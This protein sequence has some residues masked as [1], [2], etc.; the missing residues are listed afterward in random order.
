ML[1]VAER[2]FAEQGL[3]AVSLR[4]VGQEAGQRNNSA[5]QYHFGSRQGLIEAII[6]T[7]SRPV[8]AR[9][10]ELAARASARPDP[11]VRE[12]VG[13]LVLPLVETL[14]SPSHYLRFLARVVEQEEPGVVP[15]S[16]SQRSLRYMHR[17]LR[18]RLPE[19]SAVTF[20]R[21]LR[22]ATAIGLRTLADLEREA[23]SGSAPD[24]RVVVADLLVMLEALML[25]PDP[26]PTSGPGQ[27]K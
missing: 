4:A 2:L 16:P 9:R 21:R 25:A 18:A 26:A 1:E 17:E 12:L 24:T 15:D 6:E 20:E 13:L 3:D 23:G 5:A 10:A 8:E 11:P 27:P 7:R 22:W 19:L 14:A